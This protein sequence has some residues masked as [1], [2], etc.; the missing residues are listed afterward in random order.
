VY[1]HAGVCLRLSCGDT[2]KEG[3][4]RASKQPQCSRR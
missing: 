1:A 3:Q 4:R 2:Q